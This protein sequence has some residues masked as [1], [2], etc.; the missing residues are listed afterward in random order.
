MHPE[1]SG[2]GSHTTRHKVPTTRSSADCNPIQDETW[3]LSCSVAVRVGSLLPS[4]SH[5]QLQSPRCIVPDMGE[6]MTAGWRVLPCKDP[7]ASP[8]PKLGTPSGL[9]RMQHSSP[10]VTPSPEGLRHRATREYFASCVTIYT[11]R[12]IP[13]QGRGT[14][15]GS[16]DQPPGCTGKCRPGG[17]P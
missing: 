15:T 10:G 4:T 6:R 17:R 14:A 11:S 2:V 5:Y 9:A 3:T 16:G 8:L 7:P 12:C 13:H 1:G